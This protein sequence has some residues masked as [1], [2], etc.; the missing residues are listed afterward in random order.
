MSNRIKHSYFVVMIDFG[1]RGLEAVV[2]PEITR[3]EV[4]SRIKSGEYR[5]IV[6][7]HHVDDLLVEDVTGELID[8]AEAEII[9]DRSNAA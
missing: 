3:R 6:F 4:I 8:A 1:N 5:N 7:I 2:D 9:E